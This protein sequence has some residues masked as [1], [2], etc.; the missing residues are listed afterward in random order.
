MFISEVIRK[1]N[2][3]ILIIYVLSTPFFRKGSL[4]HSALCTYDDRRSAWIVFEPEMFESNIF[5]SSTNNWRWKLINLNF[6]P[7]RSI[8]KSHIVE[9]WN[10]RKSTETTERENWEKISNNE[11]KKKKHNRKY[12]RR[13]WKTNNI[14]DGNDAHFQIKYYRQNWTTNRV[15]LCF[16]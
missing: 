4:L 12:D 9:C 8:F 14:N 15:V 1:K 11:K 2:K 13:I 16:T 5:D 6:V 3:T 7:L 10:K